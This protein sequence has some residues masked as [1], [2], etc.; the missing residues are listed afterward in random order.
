VRR[1]T[2]DPSWRAVAHRSTWRIAPQLREASQLSGRPMHGLALWDDL[3]YNWWGEGGNGR[4]RDVLEWGLTRRRG[5]ARRVN[6]ADSRL[7]EAACA[8]AC[9]NPV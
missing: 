7:K 8:R 1:A 9:S 2:A 5:S 4:C 6:C 3:T